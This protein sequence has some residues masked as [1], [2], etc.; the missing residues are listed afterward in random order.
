MADAT[1]ETH[2]RCCATCLLIWPQAEMLALI[3]PDPPP[4]MPIRALWFC[5]KTCLTAWVTEAEA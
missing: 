5:N 3:W 4:L 2:R 1:T